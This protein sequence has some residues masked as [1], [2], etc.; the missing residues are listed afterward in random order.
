[1][2]HEVIPTGPLE[3]NCQLLGSKEQGEALL[4][5][6]GGDEDRLLKRLDKL[7]LKLTHIINTHGHFDH[8]G[9]V[10]ALKERTGCQF[11]IH[12]GDEGLVKE[13]GRHASAWG[14]PFGPVPSIDRFLVADEKLQVAGITLEVVHT[15]GHTPGGVCLRWLDQV[16]VGD[17][18]FAG[19]VGRTDLPGGNMEQLIDS[20][21]NRLLPL[22][23]NLQCHPGH[24]PSSSLGREKRSNPFLTGGGLY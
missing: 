17:T 4:I 13:A 12:Q 21:M 6:P 5:D 14:L 24:G 9:A 16:A 11:W 1:M 3:V 10:S 19:S 18:L 23:D 20:I 8:I 15:P 22:G 7:G 2:I